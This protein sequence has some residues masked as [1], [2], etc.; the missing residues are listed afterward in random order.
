MNRVNQLQWVDN[1]SK[2]KRV[3]RVLTFG[4]AA[5]VYSLKSAEPKFPGGLDLRTRS[6]YLL[7]LTK[8]REIREYQ[9]ND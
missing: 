1:A 3:V 4:I 2:D 5:D 8:K 9:S 6:S 7:H